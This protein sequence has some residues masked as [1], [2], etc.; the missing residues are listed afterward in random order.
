MS[1]R[2]RVLSRGAP[3]AVRTSDVARVR[4]LALSAAGAAAGVAI[5]VAV[6][7][8]PLA[9]E[10]PIARPHAQVACGSCHAEPST[11]V[12]PLAP[13]PPHHV[14]AACKSCHGGSHVSTRAAH[15]SLAAKGE[16]TC[17]TCHAQH[18]GGQGVTFESDR[19]VRWGAGSEV[20]VGSPR[21]SAPGPGALAK[22]A[23]VP[24]VS[25]AAC[26]K[27]HDPSRAADPI[28]ACV[29]AKARADADAGALLRTTPS[30]CFDEHVRL[31]DL[32]GAAAG[33]ER[34]AGPSSP[35][36]A[37]QHGGARFVAWEAA[38]EIGATTAWVAPAHEKRDALP[39][40]PAAGAVAG[41]L[42]LAAGAAAADRRRRR[43]A[44][45]PRSPAPVVPAPRKRLPMIDPTTCLGCY[46]CVDA[47]PFDVLTID[48]YVAVVARPEECCG[49]VLCEQVCPNGSLRVEDGEPILDRP[50]TDEH[51][52]SRDVPG[53]FLAGDLTGLPLIK[54]AINQG[55]RAVDRIAAT[56]PRRRTE[57]LD[58]LVIGAGP[59]GLSAALRAKEKGL[60]CVVV[61]QATVAASIKSFPRDKIV[62]DPP[63]DLP[64][65]GELWL[66]QATKEELLA[67]WTRI[68]RARGL[69][70]RE[71]H[72]VVDLVKTGDGFVVT[73]E[74]G[75]EASAET[76]HREL[77]AARVVLAIGRRGTPRRLD[78]EIER[79]AEDRLAYA[80]ADA[81][82]FEG[83]RVLVVGLGDSAM[84]A[85]LALARQPGTSVTISYRGTG[86][87]RGKAKNVAE[88]ESLI[89][90]KK[91]KVF[92]ETVP[93]AMTRS[94]VT[95]AGTGPH[96]G[97]RSVGAD[98]M[99]VLIG[100]V[101][102][103]GLLTRAGIR[104]P[105]VER[106]PS[107]A[108]ADDG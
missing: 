102:A 88:L 54:N 19:V 26:A 61:E 71:G 40:T 14:A 89:A 82:S 83:K 24:L 98:A 50:A 105:S 94:T 53:L 70:V 69:D 45:K 107:P 39:W 93:V 80:L 59:A 41:A 108:P 36:C 99:L 67:Q 37:S 64:V 56:L 28:S 13:A 11:S 87:A 76:S 3:K 10:R 15:R 38:R 12:A 8:T 44:E 62:H 16:L 86:F 20:A 73:T 52:E 104:R 106:A 68:V 1:D 32:R 49:V 29:P 42:V 100:G 65:E 31:E 74:R 58:L 22:G 48:K 9:T 81:R 85:A 77:R 92:F 57:P 23:T 17:A 46:A 78:L 34:R 33:G 101:P 7:R 91:V 47:C 79:G 72:R 75:D 2:A 35:V 5:A 30:Q 60:S 95:L 66:E 96:A 6:D 4:T 21:G 18:A 90:Q 63:L 84:E 27:C 103:W 25:L 55:A 97:R 51:L 43:A